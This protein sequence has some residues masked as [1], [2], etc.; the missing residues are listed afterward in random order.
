V[1][2][3][4]IYILEHIRYGGKMTLNGIMSEKRREMQKEFLKLTPFQR[5]CKMDALLND[6]IAFKAKE[7]G[8][9]EYEI[10]QGY[11]DARDKNLSRLLEPRQIPREEP[12]NSD[13]LI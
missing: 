7:K 8:V 10:Y 13:L 12:D 9:P 3:D 5:I 4:K 11:L 2:L 6:I 1:S